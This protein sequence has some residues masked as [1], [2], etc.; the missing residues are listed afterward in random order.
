MTAPL[1]ITLGQ[2]VTRLVLK[3]SFSSSGDDAMA[4]HH[5]LANPRRRFTQGFARMVEVG[6]T[7][8]EW[9]T[10]ATWAMR[11]AHSFFGMDRKAQN[12]CRSMSRLAVKIDGELEKLARHPAYRR[13]GA[14]GTTTER[15][16]AWRMDLGADGYLYRPT[17]LQCLKAADFS[18]HSDPE[19]G[20]LE[21]QQ[22]KVRGRVF[23]RWEFRTSVPAGGPR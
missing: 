11:E 22:E 5:A 7:P 8:D 17:L 18:A 6:A 23:T 9:E 20:Y 13:I 14:A 19:Q 2:G 3:S 4:M 12:F 21:P 16:P 15:L 1:V 10:L